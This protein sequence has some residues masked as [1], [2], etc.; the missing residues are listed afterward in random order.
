MKLFSLNDINSPFYYKMIPKNNYQQ[1]SDRNEFRQR[2][3]EQEET[4]NM[5]RRIEMKCKKLTK[6]K[7]LVLLKDLSLYRELEKTRMKD[8]LKTIFFASIAHEL[9]NPINIIKG[10]NDDAMSLHINEFK[11]I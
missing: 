10:M 2:L 1:D 11:E 5:K 4:K 9:L 6:G 7:L 3:E 8:R